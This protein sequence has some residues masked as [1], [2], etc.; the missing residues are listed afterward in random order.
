MLNR[1]NQLDGDSAEQ[2]NTALNIL[3]ETCEYGS[4][5]NK[6]LRDRTVVGIRDTAMSKRLQ[7]NSQQILQKA[8]KL[9]LQKG[10]LRTNASSCRPK[11]LEA[12]RKIKGRSKVCDTQGREFDSRL[13][14]KTQG[15][16]AEGGP[17]HPDD[18]AEEHFNRDVRLELPDFWMATLKRLGGGAGSSRSLITRDAC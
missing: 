5:R 12:A 17:P 13:Y 3:V 8:K 9:V 4:L 16:D 11:R 2:Y 6:M 15:A 7:L 14:Y 10:Q 1:R 18:S